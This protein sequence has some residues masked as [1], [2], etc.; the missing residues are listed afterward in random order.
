[1]PTSGAIF[2]IG[3]SRRA[4]ALG[5]AGP[6]F[7][8][9][10][11]GFEFPAEKVERRFR[12]LG[13]QPG[14]Q[15]LHRQEIV[16]PML[17]HQGGTQRNRGWFPRFQRHPGRLNA[18]EQAVQRGHEQ[19][20]QQESQTNHGAINHNPASAGFRHVH[21]SIGI[22]AIDRAACKSVGQIA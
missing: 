17:R 7:Q 16:Q 12:R 5:Q 18:C 19:R 8:F 13:P 21:K 20:H 10:G 14:R 15:G 4:R 3:K 22:P 9:L 6:L 2:L 1:M 11:R